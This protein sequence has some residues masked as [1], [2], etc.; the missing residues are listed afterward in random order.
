MPG[1]YPQLESA[2]FPEAVALSGRLVHLEPMTPDHLDALWSVA[3]DT[4]IWD[5]NPWPVETYQEM[6]AY[7]D[8]ALSRLSQ[9]SE[10]P[11][12]TVAISSGRVVGST[13]FMNIEPRHR[14]LEIGSTWLAPEW[15]RTGINREAK[16]LMLSAAF[17]EWGYDRVELK[18]DSLNH[19]SRTAILKLGAIEEGTLRRHVVTRSGRVRDTVYYS[20][21]GSEWPDVRDRLL[22]G[23][24]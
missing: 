1:D 5:F 22:K 21:V 24:E 3:D 16:L 12:V 19:Q 10:F 20:I 11:Y 6:R 23:L 15:Q 17:D 14:R 4:A 13:R 18:T 7:V 2:R 9:R 8:K